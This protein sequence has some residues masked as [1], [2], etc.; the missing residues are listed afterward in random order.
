M[1]E[2]LVIMAVFYEKID[3]LDIREFLPDVRIIKVFYHTHV[4]RTDNLLF[5]HNAVVV[6]MQELFLEF[7]SLEIVLVAV[8]VLFRRSLLN[9]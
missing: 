1:R 6:T 7:F 4:H 3:E 9:F 2:F 8:I 5:F